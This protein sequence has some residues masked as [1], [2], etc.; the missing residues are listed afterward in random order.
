MT[1][2]AGLPQ[3]KRKQPVPSRDIGGNITRY[4]RGSKSRWL[5]RLEHRYFSIKD[6]IRVNAAKEMEHGF[7]FNAAPVFLAIGISL[8]FVAPAEPLLS[9][10]LI[11]TIL[12]VFIRSRLHLHGKFY[13]FLSAIMI[14]IAGMTVSKLAVIRAETPQIE[15]Q[16][17]AIVIGDVLA[18]DS[19][20]RGSPRLTIIPRSIE[21]LEE[22]HLPR[23]LRLSIASKDF[24]VNPGDRISGLARIQPVS[25]P[26]LPGGYDFSFFAW[27]EGMGG[28]GF[29]M[30]KPKRVIG[31]AE[32]SL[33]EAGLAQIN[34]IRLAI[35]DRI[36]MALPGSAGDI[37]VALIIG[38]RTGIDEDIQ[39]SLRNTGLA[40]ILAISGLHMALV[41]LTV[42][43][44]VRYLLAFF[45][46][47]VLH[48]PIKK[49]AVLAGFISSTVYLFLSGAGVATQRAWIMISVMML[50]ALLDRRAITMRSVAVSAIIILCLDPQSLFAPGFQMS[51][52][53]VAALVA[54]YEAI[55]HRRQYRA[56]RIF[57][58]ANQNLIMRLLRWF[59]GYTGALLLTSLIAGTATALIAAW[60]FYRIAPLGLLANMLAMPLVGF[61]VMPF[62]LISMLLMP[63]GFEYLPLA[64]VN[65]GVS[66]VVEIAHWVNELSN[67]GVTGAIPIACLAWFGIGISLLTLC[68]T[69]LRYL[70]VIPF[71]AMIIAYQPPDK[72]DI[73]VSENGR[74]IAVR[75]KTEELALLYPRRNPF[76]TENWRK[77]S[78]INRY[79][80]LNLPDEQCNRDRRIHILPTSKV[81]HVVYAPELLASS[82]NRADILIAPR[83]WWVRCRGREPQ[84][85]L[86]RHDFE[87]HGAHAIYIRNPMEKQSRATEFVIQTAIPA[88]TRPWARMVTPK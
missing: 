83:L 34:S 15:R 63:F 11:A 58:T 54:G 77:A 25:G 57:H 61:L 36:K 76:V 42:I 23:K 55:N 18:V 49:W 6:K 85:I 64:I 41:T 7:A 14:V 62:I 17:T 47:L 78:R 12:P 72:P 30:G 79:A 69:H 74:A 38:D 1:E 43:G 31:A 86:R 81:L 51:F 56:R 35:R 66:Q 33:P 4:S 21:G 67:I 73:L 8:Y 65:V 2:K 52:A 87:Q 16:I 10:L 84:L 46:A 88:S 5:V 39:E 50:A 19:N 48:Y 45:P 37:A 44:A 53:A 71:F 70:A 28:S 13:Y 82:C 68:R 3:E 59:S 27:F 29:F 40:H 9:A 24:E 32:L 60:H 80:A 26:A 22:A 75:T 20:R